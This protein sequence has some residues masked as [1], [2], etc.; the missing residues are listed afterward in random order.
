L[1]K[2][3]LFLFGRFFLVPTLL[4]GVCWASFMLAVKGF[5]G[6][7]GFAELVPQMGL[8]ALHSPAASFCGRL[9]PD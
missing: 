3:K 5:L 2:I 6:A 7:L 1:A 8:V 9:A 4:R